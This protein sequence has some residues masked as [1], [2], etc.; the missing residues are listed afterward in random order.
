MDN[1]GHTDAQRADQAQVIA[2]LK[3]Y[4]QGRINE[5]VEYWN[6]RQRKQ[7]LG[8]TFDDYLVSLM[9]LSNLQ[10]FL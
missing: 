7:A 5:M 4:I 8:E 6:F 3:Q 10:F 1:L 9:E 2:G